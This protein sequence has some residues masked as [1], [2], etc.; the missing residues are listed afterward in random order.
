VPGAPAASP[1]SPFA[2]LGLAPPLVRALIDEGYTQPTPVQTRAIPAALGGADLLACAQTGTGKTA[3][4]L[5]PILQRLSGAS[6]VHAREPARLP[7]SRHVGQRRAVRALVLSPTRELAAQIGERAGA[8][9]RH[10]GVRH[11]IIYGGVSQRNQEHELRRGVDLL[12]ATPGRLLDLL[13]QRVLGLDDVEILVLDEADRMLDMGFVQDVRRIL[14]RIPRRDQTL[15][16]SATMPPEIRRLADEI[17]RKPVQIAVTPEVTAAP[18]V[19]HLVWHVANGGKRALVEKVLSSDSAARRAIVFT[20]TKRGANRVCEQLGRAGFS[21]GVIHG[22]KSQNARERALDAFRDGSMRVLVATDVAA[23]GIDVDDVGLVVNYDLPEVPESYVHR[24]GRTGRAG[25]EGAAVSFCDH[26][27]R[28]LLAGI[29][30]LL[31]FRIPVAGT[32][33]AP[34]AAATPATAVAAAAP[35]APAPARPSAFVFPGDST[36]P[37]RARPFRRRP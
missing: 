33:D 36:R 21:C 11:A 5:L 23:R 32:A 30:R 18:S 25:N 3:A 14:A 19:S 29:E 22:N 26:E 17:L 37:R 2:G 10:L 7:S 9:G 31:R 16:F 15:F 12:I 6:D 1:G 4:F 13:G 28:P 27:E 35:G 24:I 8:Y 20:R 34:A